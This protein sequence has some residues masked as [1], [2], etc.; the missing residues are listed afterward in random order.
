MFDRYETAHVQ[1]PEVIRATVHEHRAPTDQSVKLLHEFENE[2]RNKIE[3]SVRVSDSAFECVIHTMQ[4]IANNQ[5][6]VSAIFSLNGK[7]M[8][9]RTSLNQ[10]DF[11]AEKLF[12]KI[13]AGIAEMIAVEA[14]SK[15]LSP[16]FFRHS[17]AR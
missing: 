17:W 8:V 12:K 14:V 4:D 1:S 5:I 11:E 7:Q 3:Q 16:S 6:K 10:V 9:Y 13:V 15:A 2:A